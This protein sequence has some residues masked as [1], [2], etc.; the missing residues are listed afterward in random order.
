MS[1]YD[2]FD[3]I[4]QS[5]IGAGIKNSTWLFPGIEAVHLLALALLGGSVLLLDLRLL[6]VGLVG[7]TPSAVERSVR[8]FLVTALIV[9][10]VT[11]MLIGSSEAIKLYGKPAYWVKMSALA[12]AILFTFAI[13]NPFA[14]RDPRTGIVTAMVALISLALWLTVGIAGRWIG[15]S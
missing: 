13:R 9:L 6:G 5:P 2:V 8:P 11:G 14:R 15:F 12:A 4:E 1:L 3:A 7:Q 10:I